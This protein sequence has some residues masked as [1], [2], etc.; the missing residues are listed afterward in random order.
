MDIRIPCLKAPQ[1]EHQ[2]SQRG[3]Q[4]GISGHDFSP[5]NAGQQV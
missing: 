1:H 4:R 5:F 2:E 3:S